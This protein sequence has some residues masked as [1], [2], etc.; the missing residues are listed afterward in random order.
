MIKLTIVDKPPPLNQIY[1]SKALPSGKVIYY[2]TTKAKEWTEIVRWKLCFKSIEQLKNDIDLK[3]IF[4]WTKSEPD[5][6]AYIK[7]L[8]DSLEGYL[9][10]NDK[11]IKKLTVIKKKANSSDKFKIIIKAKSVK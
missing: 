4:Y 9:Y 6:D 2:K 1:R 5:I 3:I 8:L 7:L 10:Q 11:Q